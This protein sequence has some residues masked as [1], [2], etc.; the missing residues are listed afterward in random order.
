MF[1]S[2]VQFLYRIGR[3]LVV[4]FSWPEGRKSV[5]DILL[6]LDAIHLPLLRPEYQP[7]I[8]SGITHCNGY[9]NEVCQIYGYKGFDGMLA[10]DM[11][12][13]MERD[14]A[15]SPV[16]IDKC[17][18]LANTGSLIIAGI[19][20]LP[21][22]HVNVVCPGR[23]KSSGRWGNVPSCANVGKDVFIGKG[24]NWAFS[25]MPKFYGW[26]ASL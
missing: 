6:L 4:R 20:S 24:I 13:L 2:V 8:N 16:A 3:G 1:Q 14:A 10:N 7:Q 25:E 23:E 15:W 17:Q 5:K 22:G 21:H 19:K 18:F 11:V 12:D 9:V 26:R